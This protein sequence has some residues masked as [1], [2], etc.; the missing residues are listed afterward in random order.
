MLLFATILCYTGFCDFDDV[1]YCYWT[2]TK[3]GDQRDWQLN[4]G[5]T[6]SED[7]GPNKDHTTGTAQGSHLS[8]I[9]SF[10]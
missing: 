8:Y 9:S 6:G 4:S 5:S 1:D 2:N 3:D 10:L 7:T